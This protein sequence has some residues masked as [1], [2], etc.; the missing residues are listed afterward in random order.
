AR[1]VDAF[2]EICVQLN[3]VARRQRGVLDHRR[4]ALGA[5]A[6]RADPLAELDRGGA[7]AE[8]EADEAIHARTV[9]RC[10]R[11]HASRMARCERSG[12]TWAAPS[13]TACSSRTARSG[14]RRF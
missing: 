1:V 8:P 9:P 11:P 12:S 14:P 4:A 10:A 6:E 5:G 3:P 13:R 7:V 2:P